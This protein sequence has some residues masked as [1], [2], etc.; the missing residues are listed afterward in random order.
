MRAAGKLLPLPHL[1]GVL[2]RSAVDDL[3]SVSPPVEPRVQPAQGRLPLNARLG[4]LARRGVLGR[5]VEEPQRVEVSW[6]DPGEAPPTASSADASPA[7]VDA[8][9]VRLGPGRDDHSFLLQ[10]GSQRRGQ[11]LDGSPPAVVSSL[12][13][14]LPVRQQHAHHLSAN[15]I[16]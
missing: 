14:C 11:V 3:G 16:R 1:F 7:A 13:V 9:P 6:K 5:R 12:G 10:I 2:E 4:P 15:H 8:F